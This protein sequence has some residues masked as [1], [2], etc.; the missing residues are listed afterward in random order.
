MRIGKRDGEGCSLAGVARNGD[1]SCHCFGQFLDD[2]EAPYE[3]R[4]ACPT[5]GSTKRTRTHEMTASV[6]ARASISAAGDVERGLND[7]R[8]AVLGILVGIALTVGFGV[9][10][11][12]PLRVVAG[13][14]S[15]AL[16][17]GLIRWPW[18]RHKLMA[19]MHWLTGQWSVPGF[20]FNTIVPNWTVGDT[21]TTGDGR[22]FRIWKMM[23]V[24]DV[25]ESIYNAFEDM[26][27]RRDPDSEKPPRRNEFLDRD[28]SA[29]RWA[30]ESEKLRKLAERVRRESFARGRFTNRADQVR[31]VGAQKGRS[32]QVLNVI[33]DSD[34]EEEVGAL[35]RGESLVFRMRV[36][37]VRK[38]FARFAN[39]VRVNGLPVHPRDVW[40]V[41]LHRAHRDDRDGVVALGEKTFGRL[42]RTL[43]RARGDRSPGERDDDARQRQTLEAN[44]HTTVLAP[45]AR[46][47]LTRSIRHCPARSISRS[48][49]RPRTSLRVPLP[50]VSSLAPPDPGLA[51]RLRDAVPPPRS[52]TA[53][54]HWPVRARRTA[55]RAGSARSR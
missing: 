35:R 24:V 26:L 39:V 52:P 7:I 31:A 11:W 4:I 49:I 23:P 51:R 19:F 8:L 16:A 53:A 33:A 40:R 29:G 2:G 42:M 36:G 13:L 6:T 50:P 1:C 45:G 21:F 14:A 5:C 9:P 48:E 38:S 43:A 25:E 27:S 34:G 44:P 18:S 20:E 17:A 54:P 41:Q 47:V 55:A 3:E 30:R 28:K 12:W 15:F 10:V 37:D 46:I 32:H 22:K